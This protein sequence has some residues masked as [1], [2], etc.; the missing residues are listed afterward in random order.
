MRLTRNET[1]MVLALVT[2]SVGAA[3]A[4]LG[5]Q[6]PPAPESMASQEFEALLRD[7]VTE[8]APAKAPSKMKTKTTEASRGQS[9]RELA[10][11]LQ[12][13]REAAQTPDGQRGATERVRLAPVVAELRSLLRNAGDGN[14]PEIQTLPR[15]LEALVEAGPPAG[16]TLEEWRLRIAVRAGAEGFCASCEVAPGTANPPGGGPRPGDPPI[17][18]RPMGNPTPAPLAPPRADAGARPPTPAATMSSAGP[19][20]P[21]GTTAGMDRTTSVSS[22][23]PS[24]AQG[25]AAGRPE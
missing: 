11:A 10:S 19:N 20:S 22:P 25:P 12:A 13:L 23:Q 16:L 9:A 7:F 2:V 15:A 1:F 6:V 8:G 3:V 18:P 14:P 24:P 21:P 17:G 5:A 4:T